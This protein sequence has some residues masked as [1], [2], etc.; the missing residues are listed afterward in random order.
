MD[1]DHE[2]I[3]SRENK[4]QLFLRENL[5][6]IQQDEAKTYDLENEFS[7]TRA[8]RDF[9]VPGIISAVVIV[10]AAA[11]WVV[12]SRINESSRNVPVDITVF[13]DINLKNVLDIAKK[14]EATLDAVTEERITLQANHKADLSSLAL[15][16]KSELDILAV[17]KMSNDERTRQK[18]AIT[19]TYASRE[20]KIVAAYTS[21][22]SEID[23][24]LAEARKQVES[25]D[26]KRVEEARAQKKMLDNQ[27]DLYELEKKKMKESYEAEIADLRERN[28]E[29]EEEN[30][31][32]KTNQVK[33]MIEEYQAQIST[34]DPLFGDENANA[35]IARSD[36]YVDP[37]VPFRNLPE[38]IPSGLKFGTAD[39]TEIQAGYEGIDLLLSKVAAIPFENDV[40]RYASSA[41]RMAFLA[42][43]AGENMLESAFARID[44][45][46]KSRAAAESALTSEL[47]ASKKDA[48]DARLE[49]A[50]AKLAEENAAQKLASYDKTLCDAITANGYSG[51]VFDIANPESPQLYF[52][53]G[54]ADTVLSGET[55][56]VFVYRG[57][58][59]LI[60]TLL[61]SKTE[62]GY[63][64]SVAKLERKKEILPMDFIAL[65]KK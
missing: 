52:L 21:K 53:P 50:D 61:L 47:A 33:E 36:Q 26:K 44:A 46:R 37:A 2:V 12:T 49:L 14:A 62:T 13:E 29:I 58:K 8:N 42:G 31:R 43:S 18:Q 63:S 19:S 55:P 3:P 41:R 6:S 7:K 60:A 17:K 56:E 24:R 57:A 11:S 32:L 15:Q 48:E 30:S 64:V 9:F 45:E 20:K 28:T 22:L 59:T 40:A 51:M 54:V 23:V 65:E 1:N 25:F 39:F 5:M 38:A 27:Q 10:I 16:K 35:L 34:L 4:V